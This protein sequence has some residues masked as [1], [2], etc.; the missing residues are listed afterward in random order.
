MA[1]APYALVVGSLMCAMVCLRPDIAYAMRVDSRFM[2][3][4]GKVHREAAKWV[5]RYLRGTSD[6]AL[7][8]STKINLLGYINSDLTVDIDCRKSTIGYV[9]TLGS[10]AIS[11]VSQLQK[12]VAISTTKAEYVCKKMVWLQNFLGESWKKSDDCKLY[13]DSQSA[14]HLAKIDIKYHFVHSFL[15]DG[16]F[17]LKNIHT[18][19]NPAYMLTMVVT[20]EKL[21]LCATSI[22]IGT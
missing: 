15:E 3:N 2:N 20:V 7:W 21:K 4:P 17:S 14:I 10:A 11:W 16:K 9:F 12:I 19:E 6:M 8:G 5:F 13:N 1:K 22:G 18:S